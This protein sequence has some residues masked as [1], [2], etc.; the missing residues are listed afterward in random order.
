M[1][2]K[3]TKGSNKPCVVDIIVAL[4]RYPCFNPQ[5]LCI[6]TLHGKRDFA[7]VLKDTH[8]EMTRFPQLSSWA[9]YNHVNFLM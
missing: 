9:H 6:C 5:N 2:L 8:L 7:D 4:Q 1:C 3:Q